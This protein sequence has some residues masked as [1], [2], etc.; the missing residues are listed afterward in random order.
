MADLDLR[1]LNPKQMMNIA[2]VAVAIGGQ[3]QRAQQLSQRK[4]EARQLQQHRERTAKLDLIGLVIQQQAD[5]KQLELDKRKTAALEKLRATQTQAAQAEYDAAQRKQEMIDIMGTVSVETNY[6]TRNG[7]EVMAMNEMGLNI[8]PAERKRIGDP[9]VHESGKVVAMF[10]NPDPYAE[11]PFVIEEVPEFEGA[12]RAPVKE[13]QIGPRERAAE[14]AKGKLSV[15][16]TR[17]AD[18]L[19]DRWEEFQEQNWKDSMLLKQPREQLS[20]ESL[21]DYQQA[22]KRYVEFLERR[23]HD[24]LGKEVIL[25]PGGGGYKKGFYT[26]DEGGNP[27]WVRSAP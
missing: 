5:Q 21:D 1:G 3:Q 7:L 2:E 6:G 19:N 14:T 17:G 18:W 15:E 25:H 16:A 24:A 27:E 20:A 9:W 26:V 8:K 11:R 13:V 22:T 12:E 4:L 23:L 10:S